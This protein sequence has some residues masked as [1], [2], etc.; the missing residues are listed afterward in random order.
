MLQSFGCLRLSA[1]FK[2]QKSLVDANPLI[3]FRTFSSASH[4]GKVIKVGAA[5]RPKA[6]AFH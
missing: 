4:T 3:S 1:I 2:I 5:N 6:H